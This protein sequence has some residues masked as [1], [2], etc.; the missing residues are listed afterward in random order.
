MQYQ[1]LIRQA[2]RVLWRK[3]P[4]RSY[5]RVSMQPIQI[6]NLAKARKIEEFQASKV[7]RA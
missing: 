3:Q 1:R 6:W 5:R 2:G 4:G 7:A